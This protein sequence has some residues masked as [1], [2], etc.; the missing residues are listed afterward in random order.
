MEDNWWHEIKQ[1]SPAEQSVAVG[2]TMTLLLAASAHRIGFIISAPVL[3]PLFL[4]WINDPAS[5][6]GIRIPGNGQP[7]MVS[8][9]D[10]GRLVRGP[11]YGA[12]PAGA[13]TI[14]VVEVLHVCP[15]ME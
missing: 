15:C 11:I 3:N 7:F 14:K 8:A 2:I 1:A 12:I 13:E 6:V 4:S 5:A 10:Y 9:H